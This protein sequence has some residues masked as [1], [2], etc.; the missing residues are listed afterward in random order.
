MMI[1]ISGSLLR[2]SELDLSRGSVSAPFSM[3]EYSASFSSS[4]ATLCTITIFC[5]YGHHHLDFDNYVVVFVL[6]ILPTAKVIW[7]WGHGLKCHTCTT[8]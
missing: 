8:D 4:P 1:V 3:N 7:R 2:S 5:F 6:N